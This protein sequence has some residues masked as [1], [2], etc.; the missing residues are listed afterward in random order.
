MAPAEHSSSRRPAPPWP[1]PRRAE[2]GAVADRD[3]RIARALHCGGRAR[4]DALLA[5]RSFDAIE[6]SRKP[7]RSRI[8][9]DA[10]GLR[11]RGASISCP[12]Q[13]WCSMHSG[14][15]TSCAGGDR[16]L[17]AAPGL[18]RRAMPAQISRRARLA[19]A[20]T[21]MSTRARSPP[22]RRRCWSARCCRQ[23]STPPSTASARRFIASRAF[24]TSGNGCAMT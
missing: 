15:R 17:G 21:P 6:I 12:M 22:P 20:S 13:A 2:P 3:E 5:K 11:R 8:F 7:I 19:P 1:H 4:V 23:A 9:P 16:A 14:R 24:P 10:L 18:Y